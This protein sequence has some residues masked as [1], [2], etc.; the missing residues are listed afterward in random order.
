MT[1]YT[2]EKCKGE[3]YRDPEWSD[4]DAMAELAQQFP[5]DAERPRS[6]LV[7]VCDDCYEKILKWAG[8]RIND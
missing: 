3:F 2:C 1:K 7:I 4:E 8:G 6:E 5:D